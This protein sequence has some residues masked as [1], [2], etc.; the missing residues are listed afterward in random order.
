MSNDIEPQ[1]FLRQATVV[2]AL[3]PMQMESI[4]YAIVRL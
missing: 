2:S 1:D 4:L 3:N